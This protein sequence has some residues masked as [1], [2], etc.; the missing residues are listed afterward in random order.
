MLI[1]VVSLASLLQLKLTATA[2]YRSPSFVSRNVAFQHLLA[3]TS[4]TS[5]QSSAGDS[6]ELKRSHD[7]PDLFSEAKSMLG[8]KI[9]QNT[10]ILSKGKLILYSHVASF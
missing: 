5:S 9:G 10:D 7:F 1:R 8:G 2:F 4:T 3:S 6:P